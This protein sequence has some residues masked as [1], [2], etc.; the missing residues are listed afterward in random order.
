ME[1]F[2]HDWHLPGCQCQ[3]HVPM[4]TTHT[5]I[6][7]YMFAV[8][9]FDALA[10]ASDIRIQRRQVVSPAFEPGSFRHLFASRLNAHPQTDWAIEDQAKDLNLTARPHFTAHFTSLPVGFR[11]WLRRCYWNTLF[12]SI[13]YLCQCQLKVSCDIQNT[14]CDPLIKFLGR[15]SLCHVSFSLFLQRADFPSCS[16]DSV[17]H[18]CW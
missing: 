17:A 1:Q 3:R 4:T 6:D 11:T 15:P 2:A 8:V 7:K 12:P 14:S 5:Y 10:Q 9:N 16:K 18:L 13:E